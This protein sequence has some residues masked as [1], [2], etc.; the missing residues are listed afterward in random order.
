M[1]PS[2]N[3]R[4]RC[5]KDLRLLAASAAVERVVDRRARA[6][7]ALPAASVARPS[8]PRRS[9]G[10]AIVKRGATGPRRGQAENRRPPP[11]GGDGGRHRAEQLAERSGG[12]SLHTRA[13]V[14]CSSYL[15]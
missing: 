7:A 14:P 2:L 9:H 8:G 12:Q 15:G 5:A 3:R 11:P 6:S 4:G 1:A 10:G 13:G